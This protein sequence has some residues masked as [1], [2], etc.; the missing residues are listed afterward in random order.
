LKEPARQHAKG[1]RAQQICWQNQSYQRHL[2][3]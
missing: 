1:N 3:K 2:C